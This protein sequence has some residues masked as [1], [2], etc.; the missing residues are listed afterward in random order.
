[1]ARGL[2]RGLLAGRPVSGPTARHY[3]RLAWA[4]ARFALLA[5]LAMYLIGSKLKAK[6]NLSGRF[7]DALTWQVLAAAALRRFEAEGRRTEDLPLVHYAVEHALA[8]IQEAFEAIHAN[9]DAPLVG[10]WLKYPGSLFLRVNPLSRGPGD[11]LVAPA[12]ATIQAPGEQYERLTAGIARPP[13]TDTGAS[14]LLKAFRLDHEVAPL[15]HKLRQQGKLAE[16]QTGID[17]ATL[18]DAVA[19]GIITETEAQ[20]LREAD[21]AV[22]AAWEV[23]Q[24]TPEE[25]FRAPEVAESALAQPGQQNAGQ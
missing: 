3:R 10:W 19:D 6:G 8:Q 5:D 21:R 2:S 23:D 20:Q 7:A 25:Y 11:K 18:K 4:S 22:R 24:F 16:T 15:L 9:F 12:A 13:A 14:R 17:E 1:M